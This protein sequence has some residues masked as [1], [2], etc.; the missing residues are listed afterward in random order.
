MS[1]FHRAGSIAVP[2]W[3]FGLPLVFAMTVW[4]Y[5]VICFSY[6]TAPTTVPAI[7][8]SAAEECNYSFTMTS[9]TIYPPSLFH[10]TMITNWTHFAFMP[11]S[12]TETTWEIS[13][14]TTSI[15]IPK[16]PFPFAFLALDL[17]VASALRTCHATFTYVVYGTHCV[18][19]LWWF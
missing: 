15:A 16:S 8:S 11:S 4:T 2:A 5:I 7:L 10:P 9:V 19:Y 14:V 18:S 3:R 6:L 13:C 12:V 1:T 17:F